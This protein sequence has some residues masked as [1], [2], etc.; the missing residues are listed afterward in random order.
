MEKELQLKLVE[1]LTAIQAAT[2]KAADFTMAQLPDIA[3]SYVAYGRAR[4]VLWFVV[5]ALCAYAFCRLVIYM[6][7]EIRDN[8]DDNFSFLMGAGIG[9][10]FS[11]AI[12]FITFVANASDSVLVWFAPK[13]WLL[14]ELA[15]LVK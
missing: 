14:K 1:I 15:Q 9:A 5:A 13:V 6:R 12:G 11:G 3:Q 10:F 7:N 4:A 2:G 8:G